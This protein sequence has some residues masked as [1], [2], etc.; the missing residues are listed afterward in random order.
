MGPIDA[1]AVESQAE[2]NRLVGEWRSAQVIAR[3]ARARRDAAAA[4]AEHLVAECELLEREVG[5]LTQ[6]DRQ[7]LLDELQAPSASQQAG[8][9]V[10]LGR[11]LAW[12]LLALP[13]LVVWL[14]SRLRRRPAPAG[15][16]GGEAVRF[17]SRDPAELLQKHSRYQ[18][19]VPLVRKLREEQA[20]A[21]ASEQ[22][23]AAA[24][25][26]ARVPMRG[27]VDDSA[28]MEEAYEAFS[29]K[30]DLCRPGEVEARR[31]RSRTS[32]T[33]AATISKHEDDV[34]QAVS[35]NAG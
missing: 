18:E 10:V 13:R 21:D 11:M 8:I 27:R 33:V 23:V 16:T 19:I 15:E 20:A 35:L 17:A 24:E 12:L 28:G 31:R 4:S 30:T 1:F 22:A 14:V 9:I 34:E 32:G 2:I 25:A 3:E 26:K 6:E 7:R 5:S 29:R